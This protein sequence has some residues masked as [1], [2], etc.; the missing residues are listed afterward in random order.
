LDGKVES[1][2]FKAHKAA[3]HHLARFCM[4]SVFK[5]RLRRLLGL[6]SREDRLLILINPDPDAMASAM[7]LK[8]L[9]WRKVFSTTIAGVEKI[10]RPDNLAMV[11][12]LKLDLIPVKEV[13]RSQFTRFALVDS[14]PNHHQAFQ[15]ID[16]DVIMDHHPETGV[17]ARFSDIR[18]QFG[19]TSTIMTQYLRAAK[20]KPSAKLAT[21]LF[22]GI[23]TDTMNFQR[24][25]LIDD[26]D[27]FQFLF[28]YVNVH[29]A[30]R[31]EQ[32]EMTI[33]FLKYYRIAL[34]QMRRRRHRIYAHLG[35]VRNTDVCVSIADFFMKIHDTAWSIVSAIYQGRLVIIVRTDG[36]RKDGGKLLAEKFG[37]LGSA[38]G[39]KAA[40]RAEIPV[41]SLKDQVD[42]KDSK[43][44][45]R[46]I[47]RRLNL[48]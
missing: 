41:E 39:H 16:Y 15:G 10:T 29:L 44:V 28:H 11:R 48:G 40:A 14:Q 19:A 6:F 34:E 31:I 23:K 38:G 18:P 7:A 24:K 3:N 1:S 17:T 13:D 4:T 43:A 20:I 35:P 37:Q 27:A 32:A 45:S 46:W 36:I 9:L 8:R 22:Y 30:Q 5:E 47:T 12:L 42:F 21:G 26:V 25:A 33:D 2:K